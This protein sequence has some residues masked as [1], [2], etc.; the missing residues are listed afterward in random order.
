MK[1]SKN[2]IHLYLEPEE[3]RWLKRRVANSLRSMNAELRYI[4][5]QEQAREAREKS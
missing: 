4:I 2:E 5:Q 3:I 1:K